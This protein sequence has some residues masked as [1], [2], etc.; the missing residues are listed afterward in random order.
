MNGGLRPGRVAMF[1]ET[2]HDAAGA[3]S[4]AAG[5]DARALII[6]T[7]L[8]LAA[9]LSVPLVRVDSIVWFAFYPI[10]AAPLAG[11]AFATIARRSLV[12]LPLL[13]AVAAFNPLLSRETALHIAGIDISAGWLS[14]ISILLRGL[15]ALQALLLLVHAA[16]FRNICEGLRRMGCPALMAGQLLMLHRYLTVLLEEASSMGRA[17]RARGYRRRNFD[18]RLWVPMTGALLLRTLERSRRISMAMRARGYTSGIPA[19]WGGDPAA[20]R[21]WRPADTLYCAAWGGVFA[22]LR[23]C[24][25]PSLLNHFRI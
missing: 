14:F 24:D 9:L 7:F 1:L 8:Y 11:I 19:L 18:L 16:G 20:M 6:V 12:A 2:M 15:F 5:L 13:V 25:I 17:R 21:K 10:V 23:F 22:L 3:G 4:F